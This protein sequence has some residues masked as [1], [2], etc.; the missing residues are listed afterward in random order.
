MFATA[1]VALAAPGVAQAATV[2]VSTSGNDLTCA[3]GGGACATPEQAFAVAEAGDTVQFGP[4]AFP[5]GGVDL[6]ERLILRGAQAGVDARTRAGG[7]QAAP[8]GET[9]LYDVNPAT[10]EDG[11]IEVFPAA[12]G[13]TVDG[14][15][16]TGNQGSGNF[17]GAGLITYD[18]G[19]GFTIANNVMSHNTFGFYMSSSGDATV[20]THN[21]FLSNNKLAAGATRRGL[22][23]ELAKNVTIQQNSFV[24]NPYAATIHSVRAGGG[25][26]VIVTENQIIGGGSFTLADVDGVKFADNTFSGGT[27]AGVV[28]GGDGLRKVQVVRNAIT[29][30]VTGGIRMVNYG[31]ADE[32]SRG[33]TVRQNTITGT[34]DRDGGAIWI[35]P[36]GAAGEALIVNNRI[37]D[38]TSAGLRNEDPDASVDARQNWW[39][40][41]NGPGS[42]GCDGVTS[43]DGGSNPQFTPW[44]TLSLSATPSDIESG[45]TSSLLARLSNLSAGGRA[46][47]SQGAADGPFFNTAFAVFGSAPDGT[48][49]PAGPVP[50]EPATLAARSSFTAISRPTEVNVTVDNQTVRIINADPP[51]PDVVVDIEP[52]DPTLRPGQG[53]A[54]AIVLVNRGNRIARRLRACLSLSRKLDLSGA[55]CRE[56]ARL[57]PGQS[58]IYR[59]PVRA[60]LSAC[61]GGLT[62]R[63]RLQVAGQS[64]RADTAAG[65]LLAGLCRRLACPAAAAGRT[66]G[67]RSGGVA[68]R[69]RRVR[70]RAACWRDRGPGVRLAAP[71]V[72]SLPPL[73]VQAV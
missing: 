51:Q 37:V 23:S 32:Q 40:C 33:I 3:R 69:P 56:F 13:A 64:V 50:L 24:E 41:N 45:A 71:P 66:V 2:L 26:D 34:Q 38:N 57:R 16:F 52:S 46:R 11:L 73:S 9:V 62:Y 49:V 67:A 19:G 12:A 36:E 58:I 31:P 63:L 17:S 55:R 22:Y 68:D 65:R 47:A 5:A 61:R 7:T 59:V 60:L 18:G 15:T 53:A 8:G 72:A 10:L 25:E 28:L 54:L 70:A 43:P 6:R 48:F 27:G 1:V 20:V 14:F 29:G 44:L 21:Q 39:G 35:G 42:A 4:G 30:K